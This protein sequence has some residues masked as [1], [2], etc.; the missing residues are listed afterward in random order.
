MKTITKLLMILAL[1]M[2]ALA[3]LN[4]LT[5]TTLSAALTNSQTSFQVA[6]GTGITGVSA[7]GPGSFLFVDR[8]LMQVISVP[9]AGSGTTLVNVMR[10]V[11]GTRATAHLTGI[12]T[13]IGNGD[14][15]AG[16]PVGTVPSGS[17]TKS[18]LYVYPDI[19]VLDGSIYTCGTLGVWGYAGP[20]GS[21]PLIPSSI[22]QIT[23]TYTALPWDNIISATSGTFTLTLPSAAA[24]PGKQYFL[25]NPGS[26]AITITT[27]TGCASLATTVS[28]NVVSNGSAWTVF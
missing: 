3:Q 12:L 6:S 22:T 27:A 8:E 19:H 20:G 16:A 18:N 14:W 13:Y 17:C 24:N 4:T 5:T 7:S 9:T 26:G 2:L 1:P 21:N 15:F 11:G 23:A 28:C 25:T 10:G